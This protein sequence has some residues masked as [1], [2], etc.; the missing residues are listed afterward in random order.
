MRSL[1][2]NIRVYFAQAWLSYHGRFAITS[3]FGYITSKLGF[4]FFLMIFFVFMGKFV[5]FDDP[6]YIVIGNILLI[7]A[8]GGMSGISMAIGEERN[9]GTLSYVLGSPAARLP[10]FLGRSFFYT[11]DGFFTALLGLLFAALIFHIDM[12]QINIAAVLVCIL[13]LS[14]TANGYGFIFGSLSLLTRDGFTI[15]QVFISFLY[16][17]IGVNFPMESLPGFL[18]K[19]GYGLPLTHGV[20]AARQAMKGASWN[21]LAPLILG[22]LAIGLAYILV[23][24]LAFRI[25]EKQSLSTGTLDAM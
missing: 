9:W 20:I 3:P 23:G 16:I 8:A 4:A 5:G 13:V 14:I 24:Y 12:V 1:L 19:V 6:A 11:V 22:E 18:S 7:P 25:I 2:H 21:V 17:L 10:V 15:L